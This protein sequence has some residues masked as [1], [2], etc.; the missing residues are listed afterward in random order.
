MRGNEKKRKW[1]SNNNGDSVSIERSEK[2]KKILHW[3]LA[4]SNDVLFLCFLC[5]ISFVSAT[6]NQ[7][8]YISS[9]AIFF[10][11][12]VFPTRTHLFRGQNFP[13][14]RFLFINQVERSSLHFMCPLLV[15][16]LP[17]VY[18]CILYSDSAYSLSTSLVILCK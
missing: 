11:W 10:Q 3:N 18:E 16:L 2:K 8:L 5:F 9:N 7:Q 13:P 1:D 6:T 17:I 4:V 15:R 14:L 12:T